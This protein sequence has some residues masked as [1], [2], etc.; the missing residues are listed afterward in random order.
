MMARNNQWTAPTLALLWGALALGA[1]GNAQAGQNIK[2][3]SVTQ[4]PTMVFVTDLLG[5][6]T[7]ATT[8]SVTCFTAGQGTASFTIGLSAG[9]GTIAQRTQKKGST[10][11]TYNLYQDAGRTTVWGDTVA[12]Q[13]TQTISGD[14]TNQ[15]FTIYGKIDNTPANLADGPGAYS[16]PTITLTLGW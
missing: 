13:L 8:F 1:L 15:S 11:L 6:L 3:C 4:P 5:S 2:N 12:N 10:V 16:D 9:T 7:S 14:I